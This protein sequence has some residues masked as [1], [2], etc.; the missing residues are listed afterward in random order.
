MCL[1]PPLAGKALQ[2]YS[3]M[4]TKEANE[5]DQLKTVLLKRYELNKE[6]FMK[7]IGGRENA[8]NVCHCKCSDR[9]QGRADRQANWRHKA[10][11]SDQK[12]TDESEEAD[13][14]SAAACKA[15]SQRIASIRECME[16]GQLKLANG[17]FIPVISGACNHEL[18]LDHW[19]PVWGGFIL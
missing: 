13:L 9:E 18:P 6:G 19:T 1:S 11:V 16:D 2:V 12:V 8:G 14:K 7:R 17:E 10:P 15:T 4:S 5:Y 3:N